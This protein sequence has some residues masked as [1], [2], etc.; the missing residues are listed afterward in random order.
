MNRP[1]L[2]HNWHFVQYV[3]L[4]C[5]PHGMK[6]CKIWKEKQE[7]SRSEDT[8]SRSAF[9]QI[10]L[11]KIHP[12]VPLSP[13]SIILVAGLPV[14]ESIRMTEDRDKWRKCVHGV[15]NPRIEDCWR[16]EQ[17][18]AHLVAVVW[19]G[20]ELLG[21]VEE[22]GHALRRHRLRQHVTLHRHNHAITT[23]SPA[24][25]AFHQTVHILLPA[26]DRHR[27]STPSG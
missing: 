1:S 21:G 6:T 7:L 5:L 11:R 27:Q 25:G 13:S 15:A 2:P 23:C 18:Q 22:L 12:P 9:R 10:H 19:A 24:P 17:K 14:E 8:S 16:T 4:S 3:T 20:L 26:N